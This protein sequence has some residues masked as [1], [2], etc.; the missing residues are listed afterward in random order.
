[1]RYSDREIAGYPGRREG[2]DANDQMSLAILGPFILTADLIFLLGS[3]VICDVECLSDLLWRLAL[4]HVCDCL[5]ANVEK[6]LDVKIIGSEDNLK[7]HLL[8]YLHELLVPFLNIRGLLPGVGI[9][10]GR[11]SG[12]IDVVDA[13]LDDL[14]ENGFVHIG[15][16]DDLIESG[17]SEIV[18]H[19]LDEH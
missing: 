4:D 8:V 6:W 10:I 15:N 11:G 2:V 5:A 3:E 9:V 13:P 12:V 19:V 1:M 16:G 7:E 17:I 14:L 18:H